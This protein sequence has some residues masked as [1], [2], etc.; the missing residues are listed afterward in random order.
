MLRV[1]LAVSVFGFVHSALAAER[2]KRWFTRFAGERKRNA[3]YRPIYNVIATVSTGALIAYVARQPSTHIYEARG[4]VRRALQAGQ[5]LAA[6]ELARGLSAVGVSEFAGLRS[7]STGAR[8]P[9]GQGPSM[10]G[11]GLRVEGPFRYS[12]HPLNALTIALLWL[13]PRMT[14]TVLA[15]NLAATVYLVAGSVHEESRLLQRYGAG[16][17]RYIEE[18]PRFLA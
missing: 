6:V 10:H 15:F 2:T 3:L 16:Y 13:N 7:V 5:A 8:E 1:V 4:P 17:K 12:R 9:E 11:D 18:G 14:T